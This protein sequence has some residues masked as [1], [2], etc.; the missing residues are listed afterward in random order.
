MRVTL[1]D[2]WF[3]YGR[4][5][6]I[7]G[8]SLEIPG[9]TSAALWGPSGSGKST[10]LTLIGGLASPQ[11]GTVTFHADGVE[12]IPAD[13]AL[14]E[15]IAWVFQTTNLLHHRTAFDNVALPLRSR[16][17][18]EHDIKRAVRCEME[19]LQIGHLARSVGF[20]LS[21]G[22]RQRVCIARALVSEPA[23]VL[24]DEPTGQLDARTSQVVSD[25]LTESTRSAG[26]TLIVATHD[27]DLAERCT[28]TIEV[29]GGTS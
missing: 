7:R 25:L 5:P 20:E 9:G 10:L 2:V 27:R 17:R 8:L 29:T 3:S 21:G 14:A 15:R 16:G 1:D 23:V 4:R 28:M 24:A 12:P 26:V 18:D 19:R 6:V 13:S 11:R 22:E